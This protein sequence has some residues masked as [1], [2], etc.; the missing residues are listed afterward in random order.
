MPRRNRFTCLDDEMM[1]V[2]NV[3]FAEPIRDY[4]RKRIIAKSPA[5]LNLEPCLDQ[6][7]PQRSIC[8]DHDVPVH[9]TGAGHFDLLLGQIVISLMH[10]L[11]K[12]QI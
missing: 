10:I 11:D 5:I 8:W 3:N 12:S 7:P 9:F 6:H 1:R 4:G 2:T